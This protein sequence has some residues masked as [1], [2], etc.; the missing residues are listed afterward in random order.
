MT[1]V[2]I[3]SWSFPQVNAANNCPHQDTVIDSKEPTETTDGYITYKCDLCHREITDVLFATQHDWGDWVVDKKPTET[4]PGLRHRTCTHATPH[5]QWEE[6]PLLE[7]VI[8]EVVSESPSDPPLPSPSDPPPPIEEL[9]PRAKYTA[10]EI[11][12]AS[13]T[14]GIGAGFLIW[15]LC[16]VV[17]SNSFL[18][19]HRKMLRENELMYLRR[20][21]KDKEYGNHINRDRNNADLD[22]SVVYSKNL[23]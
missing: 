7:P 9:P 3:L 21:R 22:N 8:T 10:F 23:L 5:T 4:E 13:V 6:M 15:A 2:V 11:A 14:G 16:I 20:R 1:I 17:A 18:L 12:T 19:Y